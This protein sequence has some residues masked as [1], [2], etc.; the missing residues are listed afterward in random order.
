MISHALT[1][2]LSGRRLGCLAPEPEDKAAVVGRD[3]DRDDDVAA[4]GWTVDQPDDADAASAKV[5][6]GHADVVRR[7]DQRARRLGEHAGEH[8]QPGRADQLEIRRLGP[9]SRAQDAGRETSPE[10]VGALRR[11]QFGSLPRL[12]WSAEISGPDL[13]T[14]YW[15]HRCTTITQELWPA[16]MT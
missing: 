12:G 16:P 14:R 13:R 8:S 6:L 5:E 1:D 11:S 3:H 9:A 10:A 7:G 2:T 4:V 15:G